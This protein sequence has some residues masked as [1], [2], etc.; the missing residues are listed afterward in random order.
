MPPPPVVTMRA[1]AAAVAAILAVTAG[2]AV[3]GTPRHG[4]S[5][6]VPSLALFRPRH[7]RAHRLLGAA[8]FVWL[9]LGYWLAFRGLRDAPR[10]AVRPWW[11]AY[12][13]VLGLLGVGSAWTASTGFPSHRRSGERNREKGFASG[14]LD[15]AATVST[16]E[17]QEHAY[18]Q[19]M[20][21]VQILLLHAL[22]PR[23]RAPGPRALYLLSAY[24]AANAWWL[25]RGRFPVHSF[26]A[27]YAGSGKALTLTNLMYRVKKCVPRLTVLEC[28]G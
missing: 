10:Y 27:N 9:A 8:Y 24:A 3:R 2:H 23:P 26:S 12:D 1:E 22:A 25:V 21:L 14:A 17:M 7:A 6:F 20:N 18:F 28:R 5:K 11:L 13:A 15:E 16:A 19:A 4:A